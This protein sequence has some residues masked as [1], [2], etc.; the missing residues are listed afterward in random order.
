MW[1]QRR[2][3]ICSLMFASL[4]LAVVGCAT[5][6][7]PDGVNLPGF[8]SGLLHGVLMPFTFIGSLFMNV[9]IYNFPNSGRWYDFGYIIGAAMI[10]GGGGA[11]TNE[12]REDD[13]AEDEETENEEP[14]DRKRG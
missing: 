13:K 5:Q 10:L 14:S 3:R 1:P 8:F 9:R 12:G 2:R 11:A 7:A 4:C 6:P